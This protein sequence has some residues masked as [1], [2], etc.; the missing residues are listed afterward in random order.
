MKNYIIT[1]NVEVHNN[2]TGYQYTTELEST[3]G[4]E[5]FIKKMC[6]GEIDWDD[7]MNLRDM[8]TEE[9]EALAEDDVTANDEKW[10]L[11]AYECDRYEDIDESNYAISCATWKSRQAKKWLRG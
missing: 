5:S 9:L 6:T 7:F 11:K 1:V 4:D 3:T 2:T 8:T 10:I